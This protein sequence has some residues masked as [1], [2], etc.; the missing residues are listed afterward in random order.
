MKRREFLTY[1]PIVG[2]SSYFLI[3]NLYSIDRDESL[4]II[5]K[6][7]EHILPTPQALST[8]E[9]HTFFAS[10]TAHNSF[11]TSIKSLLLEGAKKIYYQSG[12]EFISYSAS[13]QE[14]FLQNFIRTRYG[15]EWMRRMID[16]TIESMLCDKIYCD[17]DKIFDILELKRGEPRPKVA[18][19]YK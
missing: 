11:D 6:I 4:K 10:T 16:I 2:V 7:Q 18:Y 9:I 15:Y 12:G 13:R 5:Q 1:I 8:Q 3:K 19:I 14:S 17:N